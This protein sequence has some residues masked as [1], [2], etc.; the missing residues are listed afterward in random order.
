MGWTSFT[1]STN[2]KTDEILRREFIHDG[3]NNARTAWDVMDSATR[4]ATWYAVLKRTEP[5]G[6]IAYF[7]FVCMTQRKTDRKTGTTEFFYKDMDESCG[8]HAYDMPVRML[9][10]LD[11][12]APNPPGYAAGWRQS[13]RDKHA[14][15]RATKAPDLKAGDVL[16]C[17]GQLY[18]LVAP[19]GPRA[20]WYALHPGSGV[21]YR[22][23]IAHLARS[24]KV[25]DEVK[26]LADHFQFIHVGA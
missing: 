13:C 14:K 17:G 4:G 19:A 24:E 10:F 1:I 5:T 7:G 3:H 23:P 12:H 20:G 22:L 18:R 25:T 8:P 6:A 21:T 16:K 9:D 2:R 11:E 26:F 15:R